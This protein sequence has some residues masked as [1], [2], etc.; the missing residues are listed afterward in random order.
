MNF[1]SFG[2]TE[3]L[4]SAVTK[5][6]YTIPTPIQTQAIPVI[7]EGR[8][9]IGGAQTGTGKTAAFALPI[10]HLLNQSKKR[11]R[12]PRALVLS[13]TRELAAQVAESFRDYGSSL[14]L[15]T[16]SIYGGV[17]IN[18]QIAALQRGTDVLVAT[19]GRLLDH[20][21]QKTL[22]LRDIEIL[23]LDEADRMLDMGFVRDIRKIMTFLPRKRQNLLFSATYSPE[24]RR[25]SGEILNDPAIVEVSRKNEAAEK[26]DQSFFAITKDQK[27]HLL[28]HFIQ[29]H[30]WYQALVFVSTKHGADRLS[31]QLMKKGIPV[32]AIHG[33]KSQNARTRTLGDFKK[34]DLQVLVATDVAARGIHLEGLSHV[35]NFNLPQVAEDYIHRI[36]RTGRAGKS[37]EA[38]TFVSPDEKDQWNKILKVLKTSVNVSAPEGFTPVK[39]DPSEDVDTRGP[40]RRNNSPRAD[41]SGQHRYARS[42]GG[43]RRYA[44]ARA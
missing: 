8:D 2:L 25:L 41:Q 16:T 17:K 29:T 15:R 31:K 3:E 14:P 19:P 32:G 28:V 7:L 20:L 6:G 39:K 38:I 10:L 1:T 9:L 12:N 13:P 5:Q 27:R 43:G 30:S 42:S 26:V 36:G 21:A 24:I 40:Q 23:V 22:N 35:V 37:G 34:G 33:N 18:P 11:T 44:S 4:L